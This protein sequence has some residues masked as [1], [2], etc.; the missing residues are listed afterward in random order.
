MMRIL[1]MITCEIG[2]DKCSPIKRYNHY[3]NESSCYFQ[4]TSINTSAV[5]ASGLIVGTDTDPQVK[6]Q[7]IRFFWTWNKVGRD[8]HLWFERKSKDKL[9]FMAGR[10]TRLE[11]PGPTPRVYNSHAVEP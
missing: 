9:L 8:F 4:T 5:G 3:S 10:H 1:L 2:Y 7:D 6:Q 11:I